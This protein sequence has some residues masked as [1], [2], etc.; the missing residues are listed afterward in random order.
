M[1]T[2]EKLMEYLEEIAP[3]SLAEDYDNVG[4][5]VGN[6]ADRISRV[7][8]TLDTDVQTVAEAVQRGCKLILSHHPL[9]FHPVRRI[10]SDDSTGNTLT[11][12]IRAGINLYACHTNIDAARGGLCDYLLSL[13]GI[14]NIV[15][16]LTD[17]QSAEGIG[18]V[19]MLDH[20]VTL[21]ELADR[22]RD[23]LGLEEIRYVGDPDELVKT[24]GICNGGGG[25][26][27][28]D[29]YEMG[30]DVYIS[31]DFKH[32]HGRFAHENNMALL[33]ITHFDAEVCFCDMMA[34]RLEANFDVEA[35]RSTTC[36]DVWKRRRAD[37]VGFI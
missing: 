22:V 19:A 10:V 36:R 9:L 29:A 34:Q 30:C 15:H 24:V 4:L 3:I 37:A 1:V 26:M 17:T 21:G 33:E 11:E 2:V 32:H 20:T 13:L 8:V 31:G 35:V 6:P 25:D 23:A 12:L 18:R 5:L 7:L 16:T 27:V 14:K 28:T